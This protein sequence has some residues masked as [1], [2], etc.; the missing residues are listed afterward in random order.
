MLGV[1]VNFAAV[2]IG[3]LIGTLLKGGLKEQYSKT[4]NAGLALCVMLIGMQGGLKT[5]DVMIV[6]VSVVIGAIL[7]ELIKIERGLD[8]L[9]DWAQAKFSKSDSGFATGFVNATLLFSVGSMAVVGSLEAGLA[10]NPQTLLAK[11]A[12]DGVSAMI[13]ASSFGIGVVFSA[14][15]LT[16]YQ[17]GIALLSGVLAPLLT[18]A[19]IAEMSA[20]G[21][22]LI[23]AL[24]LNM[25][26]MTKERIRVGNMLPAILVPC[27]YFPVVEGFG[28]LAAWISGVL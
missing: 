15:P 19:L 10:N 6:I 25:L 4:I 17:G 20:V 5:S 3:G 14:I 1:W 24:S 8:R 18:D 21:S 12:I 26:E 22:I 2:I 23:I 11:A 28:R 13:F 27:V 16:I 9:G 7:G